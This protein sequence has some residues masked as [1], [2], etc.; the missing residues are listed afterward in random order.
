MT[1]PKNENNHLIQGLIYTGIPMT[2]WTNI[3]KKNTDLYRI[4]PVHNKYMLSCK[5]K[6]QCNNLQFFQ[7]S[8]SD[9]KSCYDYTKNINEDWF[10]CSD[11]DSQVTP[12]N[13]VNYNYVLNSRFYINN[14]NID[15]LNYYFVPKTVYYYNGNSIIE[16][17]GLQVMY[18]YYNFLFYNE[19]YDGKK[20]YTKSLITKDNKLPLQSFNFR[21]CTN[22]EYLIPSINGFG[23]NTCFSIARDYKFD[24]ECQCV[25]NN[26][27][28]E[29]S[30]I[31]S[32]SCTK[33]QNCYCDFPKIF[34]NESNL[35][36]CNNCNCVCDSENPINICNINKCSYFDQY[37]SDSNESNTI[38][39]Y[40][41]GAIILVLLIVIIIIFVNSIRKQ[42]ITYKKQD[43]NINFSNVK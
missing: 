35:I 4:E 27:T 18:D 41:V 12:N 19:A 11:K 38:Y 14:S 36:T 7:Y 24:D 3:K 8:E 10:I 33:F 16:K 2:L 26:V 37:Y 1:F 34:M 22:D 21:Y 28:S 32:E 29:T 39:I 40:I 42:D 13:D 25:F 5:L 15:F 31:K 9:L 23:C 30:F 17:S 20:Y 6:S 43:I